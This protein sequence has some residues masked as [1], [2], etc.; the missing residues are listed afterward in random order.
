ML[1]IEAYSPCEGQ[2]SDPFYEYLTEHVLE[3]RTRGM[4]V[5]IMGDLNGHIAGGYHDYTNK[6]GQAILD[7]ANHWNLE[8]LH[9]N[10]ATFRGRHGSPSI[11]NYVLVSREI[12]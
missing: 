11:V 10:Q 1:V 9:N 6:N 2:D 7:F 4:P 8:I 3:A 5:I 12:K